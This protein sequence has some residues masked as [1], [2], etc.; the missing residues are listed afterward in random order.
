MEQFTIFKNP[1]V[2]VG[3]FLVKF[4]IGACET[5]GPGTSFLLVASMNAAAFPN[6]LAHVA[7][8]LFGQGAL[9]ALSEVLGML[10]LS[11]C[12]LGIALASADAEDTLN[13]GAI[14]RFGAGTWLRGSPA[15]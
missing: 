8:P 11:S 2:T 12:Q 9:D 14:M 5:G 7:K 15:Y 1:D 13:G 6:A 4:T 10:P 3:P